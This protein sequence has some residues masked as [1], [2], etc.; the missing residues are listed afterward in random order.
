MLRCNKPAKQPNGDHSGGN[1]PIPA[2]FAAQ[3]H[4]SESREKARDEHTT[5][6]ETKEVRD[7]VDL[8]FQF[9]ILVARNG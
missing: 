5:T 9:R 6:G 1:D 8:Q 4:Q 2:D 7:L 3:N